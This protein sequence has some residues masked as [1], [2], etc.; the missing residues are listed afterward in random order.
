MEPDRWSCD[1]ELQFVFDDGE[2]KFL[3]IERHESGCGPFD[4]R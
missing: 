1:F 4:M 2:R 3:Q